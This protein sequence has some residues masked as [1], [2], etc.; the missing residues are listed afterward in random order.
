MLYKGPPCVCGT[1][2]QDE[3]SVMLPTGEGRGSRQAGHQLSTRTQ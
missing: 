2:G 1:G 3:G